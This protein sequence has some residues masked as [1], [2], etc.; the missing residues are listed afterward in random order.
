MSSA[1]ERHATQTTRGNEMITFKAEIAAGESASSVGEIVAS[2]GGSW[3]NAVDRC[4]SDGT[5]IV[6]VDCET[7]DDAD[8]VAEVMDAEESVLSYERM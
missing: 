4:N 1:R 2:V 5:G 6:F 7:E 8:A 3:R